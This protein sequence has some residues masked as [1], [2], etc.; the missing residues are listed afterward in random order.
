M[1]AWVSYLGSQ[2]RFSA[3]ASIAGSDLELEATQEGIE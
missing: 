2:E 1:L 3:K